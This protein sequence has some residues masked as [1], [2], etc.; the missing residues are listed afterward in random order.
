M[1]TIDIIYIY[2]QSLQSKLECGTPEVINCWDPSLGLKLTAGSGFRLA[3][4]TCLECLEMS[5]GH[6]KS[7]AP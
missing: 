1:H 5:M 3:K 6:A 2:I 7:M 4:R